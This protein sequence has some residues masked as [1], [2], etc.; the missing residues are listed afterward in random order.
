MLS[1]FQNSSY[2]NVDLIKA[3]ILRNEVYAQS[4]QSKKIDAGTLGSLLSL[5]VTFNSIL[6]N[7]SDLKVLEIGGGAGHLALT[8]QTLF[9]RMKLDW[10]NI[11][12]PEFVKHFRSTKR[13]PSGFD[14]I[15]WNEIEDLKLTTRDIVI[16]NSSLQYLSDPI[17]TVVDLI[18]F[19]D[20]KFFYVGKTP[21]TRQTYLCEESLQFSRISSNGPRSEFSQQLETFTLESNSTVISYPI[22]GV[23]HD[24][25]L[26]VF[27]NWALV[28]EFIEGNID[29][30]LYCN[31]PGSLLGHRTCKKKRVPN[32]SM[33]FVR[34]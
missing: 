10:I 6:A 19:S 12:T 25:L 16:A 14:I 7:R 27:K 26:R 4:L 15:S 24:E 33:L 3:I 21:I 11:E 31:F 22:R 13:M 18:A 23:S 28:F 2:E 5:I 8:F 9:P 17:K 20:A 29:F 32:I 34:D 30:H 1:R